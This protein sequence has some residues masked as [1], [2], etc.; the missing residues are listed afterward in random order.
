MQTGYLC[1]GIARANLSPS[2]LVPP[3][4]LSRAGKCSWCCRGPPSCRARSAA[5]SSWAGRPAGLGGKA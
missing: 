5:G 4:G 3:V 2:C 1:G